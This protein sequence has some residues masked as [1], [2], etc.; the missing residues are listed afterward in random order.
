[1]DGWTNEWVKERV[2]VRKSNHSDFSQLDCRVLAGARMRRATRETSG[3]TQHA[4]AP[5]HSICLKTG[6]DLHDSV[7]GLGVLLQ[8]SN[9]LILSF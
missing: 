6:Q 2:S 3:R 4:H 8:R 5:P 7:I 1:M 9:L